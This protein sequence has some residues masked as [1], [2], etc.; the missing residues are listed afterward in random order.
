[1]KQNNRPANDPI[2]E[3]MLGRIVFFMGG[4]RSGTTV[5]RRMLASHP[6]VRDRGEIFNSNNPQGFFKYFRERIAANP[7][8]V[9]PEHHG[10]LF[11]QYVASQVP[12]D[13]DGIALLD[14]K[15][16][17][18]NLISDAWQLP[19]TNPP[20]LRLIKRSRLKVI[21]LRRQHFY[22][23]VSNLVAVQTGRYHQPASGDASLPE[24][25]QVAVDRNTVLSSMK[26]RKRAADTV[27][28]AFDDGQRLSIDYESVFDDQGDFRP[29]ICDSVAAFLAVENQFER[30]PALKKV[31][32]EPLSAVITN[33]DEIRDLETTV[34]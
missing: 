32:D 4:V 30:Q 34:I 8:L 23:V 12:K 11:L 9:F 6:R 26:K 1:M 24:K 2:S 27:D 7:D 31:I 28:Q 21:H 5:F 17:H 10:K 22:S 19:F 25:R 14:I 29:E 15:Y 20:M 3:D 33:Y 16:E 18:L 13:A